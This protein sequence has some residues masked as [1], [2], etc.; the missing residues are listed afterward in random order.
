M[1]LY[2]N[3]EVAQCHLFPGASLD[4]VGCR[5]DRRQQLLTLRM[6]SEREVR[7][8]GVVGKEVKGLLVCGSCVTGE[9]ENLR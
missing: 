8:T 2:P 5:R 7:G 4:L 3:D 1:L 9:P 6:I